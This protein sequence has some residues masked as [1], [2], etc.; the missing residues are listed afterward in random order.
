LKQ[1]DYKIKNRVDFDFD[2][3]ILTAFI[4]LGRAGPVGAGCPPYY[5]FYY[6]TLKALT[7]LRLG[8]AGPVGAGCPSYYYYLILI[9]IFGDA[10]TLRGKNQAKPQITAAVAWRGV[11]AVGNPAVARLAVPAATAP[12]AVGA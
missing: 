2:F 8:R 12:Y 3:N 10:E 6:L 7:A 4:R 11:V 9:R 5:Y 1:I